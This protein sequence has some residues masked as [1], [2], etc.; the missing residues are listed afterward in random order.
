ML[1]YG[2][3][4]IDWPILKVAMRESLRKDTPKLFG[5]PRKACEGT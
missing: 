3:L 1:H 2:R 4:V 5:N